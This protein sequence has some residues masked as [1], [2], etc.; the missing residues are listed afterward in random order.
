MEGASR[1]GEFGVSQYGSEA[2]GNWEDRKVEA[3][4][5]RLSYRNVPSSKTDQSAG[6]EPL[7]SLW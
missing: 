7:I 3:K 2:V 5:A 4:E 1:L 6:Y